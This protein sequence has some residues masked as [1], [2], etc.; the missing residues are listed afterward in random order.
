MRR[1]RLIEVVFAVLLAGWIG[2]V[3]LAMQP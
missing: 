2:L 3:L 1:N